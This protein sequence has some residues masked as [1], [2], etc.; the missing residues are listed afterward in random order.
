MS[1]EHIK[2]DNLAKPFPVDKIHWR[3]GAMTKDKTS[4]IALAY[5]DA[6][7]VMQ[8]LDE[9]VGRGNWQCEYPW[10]ESGRL[11]C[12]IGIKVEGEWVWKS[13]G[14]GDTKVEAEKGAFSD[15]FKRAG[16]LWGIAQYLYDIPNTWVKLDQYKKIVDSEMGKLKKS[17]GGELPKSQSK[18]QEPKEDATLDAFLLKVKDGRNVIGEDNYKKALDEYHTDSADKIP[19]NLRKNFLVFMG[20]FIKK[21]SE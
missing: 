13:N 17:L 15:A 11:V 16:V 20:T 14:A 5:V 4:C 19:S 2:L 3:V 8:R 12:R 7:D 9:V 6:R 18:Q 10:S 21:E 1:E